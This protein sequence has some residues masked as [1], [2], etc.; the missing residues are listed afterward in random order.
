M[1]LAR[2]MKSIGTAGY[3]DITMYTIDD[4]IIPTTNSVRKEKNP[5]TKKR[6][7]ANSVMQYRDGTLKITFEGSN[8]YTIIPA[9]MI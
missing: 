8:A 6:Q 4:R 7:V 5:W 2:I 9:K 3:A 1:M